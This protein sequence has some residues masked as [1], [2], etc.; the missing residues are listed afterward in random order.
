MI[1][2]DENT[3]PIILDNIDIPFPVEY[4]WALDLELMDFTLR[5]LKLC[6]EVIAPTLAIT[7][8][9]YL[10]EAPAFWN[11]LCY[12]AETSELDS[13]AFSDLT[14]QDFSAFVLDHRTNKLMPSRIRVLDH[15]VQGVV[16]YPSMIRNTMLCHP[17]GPYMWACI[18]P[19]DSYNK[20]L[21]GKVIGDL[22]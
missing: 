20:Y 2:F 21:K 1:I 15:N 5:K 12:S 10:I 22:L 4:F 19:T 13:I 9:D 16:Q 8:N 11:I 18:A 17:L 6:E 14:K 3:T 7:I